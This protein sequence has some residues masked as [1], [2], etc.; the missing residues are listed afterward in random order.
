[1]IY[2]AGSP[3]PWQG[4]NILCD[5]RTQQETQVLIPL[6]PSMKEDLGR[7]IKLDIVSCITSLNS[8]ILSLFESQGIGIH[9]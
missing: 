7:G 1:M 2:C 3:A 8:W 4:I 6:S 9:L 5:S